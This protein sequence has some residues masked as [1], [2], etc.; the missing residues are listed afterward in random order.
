[1]F[2]ATIE[3]ASILFSR[4]FTNPGAN[5]TNSRCAPK[6]VPA[7]VTVHALAWRRPSFGASSTSWCGSQ[8][9]VSQTALPFI[10]EI[11]AGRIGEEN[12]MGALS[13]DRQ[14]GLD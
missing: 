10:E 7:G 8:R 5:A 4:R 6:V 1:M 12:E 2:V 3:R 11:S 9:N 13:R 14:L